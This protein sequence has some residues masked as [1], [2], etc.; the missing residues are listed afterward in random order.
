[1][2]TFVTLGKLTEQGFKNVRQWPQSV[3]QAFAQREQQGVKL[4]GYW[5]TE[6]QYD[7]VAIVDVPDEQTGLA[8]LL[9]ALS[10]GDFRSETLRGHSL[11]ELEQVVQKMPQ[12]S[13]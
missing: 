10:Q 12:G 3:R 4:Q 6:G 8:G 11:D 7:F 13:Q 1:M 2:P 5:V 9:S